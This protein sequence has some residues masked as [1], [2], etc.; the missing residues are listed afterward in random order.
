MTRVDALM[1]SAAA[2]MRTGEYAEAH[3][4]YTAATRIDSTLAA[5]WFGL[6]MAGRGLGLDEAADSALDRARTLVVNP[7]GPYSG[8]RD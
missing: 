2:V 7:I 3:R 6:F 5:P 1:D 8:T 4:L